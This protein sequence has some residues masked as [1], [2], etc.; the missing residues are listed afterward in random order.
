M[1]TSNS[2]PIS[3]TLT[4]VTIGGGKDSTAQVAKS[5]MRLVTEASPAIS[6][7]GSRL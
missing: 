5:W 1:A 7:N 2:T 3:T 6:V 4:D